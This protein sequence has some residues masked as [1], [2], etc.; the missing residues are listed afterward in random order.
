MPHH[1]LVED[2]I[3]AYYLSETDTEDWIKKHQVT[4]YMYMFSSSLSWLNNNGL[5]IPHHSVLVS[6]CTLGTRVPPNSV[7]IKPRVIELG[8]TIKIVDT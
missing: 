6:W 3:K 7:I 2:Y 8:S 1:A 4:S 5:T